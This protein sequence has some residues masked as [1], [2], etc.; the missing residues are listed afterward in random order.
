MEWE[1]EVCATDIL[2]LEGL[3]LLG[4]NLLAGSLLQADMRDGGEVMIEPL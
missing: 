4:V 1:D 2:A 3:P